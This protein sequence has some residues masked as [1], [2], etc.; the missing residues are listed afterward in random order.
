MNSAISKYWFLI[1]A[2]V[3]LVGLFSCEEDLPVNIESDDGVQ[4]M[5]IKIVNAG[6][7]GGQVVQGVVDEVNKTV[8]FPRLDTLTDFSNLRFEAEM[9]PGATLDQESYD[10]GLE[11]GQAEKTM[12]IKVVNNKRFREYLVTIRLLVPVYGEM[13]RAHV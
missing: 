7:D 3:V 13:G 10:V 11:D 1:P 12:V 9:S 8:S 4:L 5:S 2:I 6:G